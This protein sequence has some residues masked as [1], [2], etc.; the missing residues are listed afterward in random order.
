MV[1]ILSRSQS[2]PSLYKRYVI[3]P[4]TRYALLN[5]QALDN[6]RQLDESVLVATTNSA[7]KTTAK[8]QSLLPGTSHPNLKV[9]YSLCS[10]YY[11]AAL[12]P[13]KEKI[14]SGDFGSVRS[15]ADTALRDGKEC[16]IAFSMAPTSPIAIVRE[17][18]EFMN[19]CSVFLAI[20]HKLYTIEYFLDYEMLSQLYLIISNFNIWMSNSYW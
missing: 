11:R 9:V 6:L 12:S 10:N 16:W 8:I 18:E 19:Y 13:A 7:S 4:E 20:F 5:G 2:P 3:K 14:G 17:N 15:A 1:D